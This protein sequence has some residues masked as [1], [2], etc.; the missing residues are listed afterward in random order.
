[1]KI[2]INAQ[3]M[4]MFADEVVVGRIV[5]AVKEGDEVKKDG[6]IRI[7]FIDMAKR[8]VFLEVVLSPL[9]VEAMI[10]ILKENLEALDKEMKSKELPAKPIESSKTEEVTYIG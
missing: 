3:S 7:G 6:Y 1:M 10:K 5:K 9:T 4:P 8:Q 2:E